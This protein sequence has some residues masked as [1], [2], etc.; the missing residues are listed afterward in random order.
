MSLRFTVLAS[1]SAGNASLLEAD[2][3]G[4]LV[5][6]G[7][8][9]RQLAARL[10]ATERSWSSVQA[11][12]LTHTHTDH[13]N[14]ATLR[15]LYTNGIPL[16]C[17][18][19]HLPE[20]RAACPPPL[21][22]KLEAARL[23]RTYGAGRELS[24]GRMRCLPLELRHDGGPTF[25]FH[26]S[27]QA[28]LFGPAW[29][30]GYA[31]DLGTWDGDLAAALSDVDLLALEFNH[32]VA[33]QRSSGRRPQ[34]IARVLGDNG[35]LSNDQA[36]ELLRAT[37]G[38]STQRR[39][40]TLVQLHLS[41]QCNR[42][43]LAQRAAQAVLAEAQLAV[44]IHAAAQD[45]ASPTFACGDLQSKLAVVETAPATQYVGQAS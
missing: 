45:A 11:I 44:N 8:G 3:F 14:V 9:P 40:R 1:G 43:H 33:M 37:L 21:Y 41:R 24:F 12:V 25:G 10:K 2:G 23:I 19:G 32:D 7:L 5:D 27:G 18:E 13:W 42:P 29:A 20:L 16:H 36:A 34:L 26:F 28:D 31:A 22:E 15:T 4:L 38:R 17:H 39:L 6:V 35:H 30:V